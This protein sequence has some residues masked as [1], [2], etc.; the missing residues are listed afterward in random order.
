MKWRTSLRLHPVP[1]TYRLCRGG[2]LPIASFCFLPQAGLSLP[3]KARLEI[4]SMAVSLEFASR[5]GCEGW[6]FNDA[7]RY[8]KCLQDPGG[9]LFINNAG[10]EVAVL[11]M[12]VKHFPCP[13]S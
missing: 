12:L 3:G 9:I 7:V 1:R 4:V 2:V 5:A 10:R 6:G 11:A 13:S 8:F